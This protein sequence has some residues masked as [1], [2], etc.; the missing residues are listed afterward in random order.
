MA[1]PL[2]LRV[3]FLTVVSTKVLPVQPSDPE[4]ET[5]AQAAQVIREGGLVAFP[6]ETVYG[7]GA[8]ALN[9]AAV[10]RIFMAKGRPAYDPLIVH[11]ASA[12]ELPRVASK[13]PD[14]AQRLAERFWPGPLTLVLPRANT[15]PTIVTAG[16]DT[17][18][19]RCPNHPVALALLRA[20]QTPIAAPSAN[21]FGRTSPTTAQ[22]V[23]DDLGGRIDLILDAGPTLIGVESTVLDLTRTTPTILRPGGVP[24]EV[25]EAEIGPIALL[26]QV[27]ALEMGMPSPGLLA[28]HYAPRAALY[29]FLGPPDAV[30]EAMRQEAQVH[31]AA[32]RRVGIL[33]ADEDA[34]AFADLD[35]IGETV[36]PAEDLNT[37]ARRLFG[38]LRALDAQG[39]DVILARDFGTQGLGSAVQDR[40]RRAADVIMTI[41]V[42]K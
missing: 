21:R 41:P 6:T 37:I 12:E 35:V 14:L 39:V 5:I 38:A 31:L 15:V 28:R 4:S 11:I 24:R 1:W 23:L 18:A 22:H 7:L 25:L 2:A 26:E 40:L 42:E 33:V 29:L 19:V 27:P 10:A 36:G 17:V 20:S 32:H 8:D 9:D 34:I 30:R 16:R 3:G 13:V